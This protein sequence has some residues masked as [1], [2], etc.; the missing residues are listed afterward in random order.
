MKQNETDTAGSGDSY[1]FGGKKFDGKFDEDTLRE[2]MKKMN[3][4]FDGDKFKKDGEDLN[5]DD[6]ATDATKEV[7]FLKRKCY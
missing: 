2:Y 6:V 7:F 1:T 3:I 4:T 5:I